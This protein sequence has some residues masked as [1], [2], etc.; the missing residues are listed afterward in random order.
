[1]HSSKKRR[2][3]QPNQKLES[4]AAEDEPSPG[5]FS[6]AL[7]SPFA[8]ALQTNGLAFNVFTIHFPGL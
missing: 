3:V 8:V 4:E 7:L 2:V 1:M 5:G 6:F